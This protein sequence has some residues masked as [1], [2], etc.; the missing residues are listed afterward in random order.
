MLDFMSC[1]ERNG[2][3]HVARVRST[4]WLMAAT[5]CSPKELTVSMSITSETTIRECSPVPAVL[6]T[7]CQ[8]SWPPNGRYTGHPI[9]GVK[10]FHNLAGQNPAGWDQKEIGSGAILTNDLI[11][12]LRILFV[13]R[14]SW[15]YGNHSLS[16]IMRA[17]PSYYN[18]NFY[19]IHFSSLS[20]HLR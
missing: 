7:S 1:P 18:S 10:L 8:P 4:V 20:L 19:G 12:R 17:Q 14:P 16:H 2:Q 3:I 9:K 6:L 13:C 15:L 5:P 11:I